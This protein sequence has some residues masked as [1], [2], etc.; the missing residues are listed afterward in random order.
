M[1][2]GKVYLRI[3]QIIVFVALVLL[4]DWRYII[5]FLIVVLLPCT[6]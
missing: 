6:S 3:I 2:F 5:A 4:F 1:R